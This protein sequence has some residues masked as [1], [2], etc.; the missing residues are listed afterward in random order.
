MLRF[1]C[2]L[3][4]KLSN[5]WESSLVEFFKFI[6]ALTTKCSVNSLFVHAY[7]VIFLEYDLTFFCKSYSNYCYKIVKFCFCPYFEAWNGKIRKP[8]Q[9]SLSSEINCEETT[10]QR[11]QIC[12]KFKPSLSLSRVAKEELINLLIIEKP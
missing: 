3:W 11:N 7:S 9:T 12:R 2:W 6:R 10:I 1:I 4:D 5:I 8:H